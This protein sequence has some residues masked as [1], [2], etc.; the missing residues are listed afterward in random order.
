MPRKSDLEQRILVAAAAAL[1][2]T[3]C[4]SA[5]DAEPAAAPAQE[6]PVADTAGTEEAE[7]AAAPAP[8]EPS[9]EPEAEPS[10]D[11]ALNLMERDGDA[12]EARSRRAPA[13]QARPA[14]AA[15]S[16][17]A[18]L[19]AEPA[20]PAASCGASCGA[21]C[22]GVPGEDEESGGDPVPGR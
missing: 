9:P 17:G 6:A 7:A 12:E 16:G 10:A 4:S 11:D 1:G 3:A 21:E 8:A 5:E 2:L 13:R 20:A 19:A 15:R 22:G 18:D 14:P